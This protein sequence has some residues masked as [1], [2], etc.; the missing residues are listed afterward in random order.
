MIMCLIAHVSHCPC[1]PSPMCPIPQGTPSLFSVLTTI[2]LGPCVPLPMCP[3]AHVP[4]PP[5]CPISTCSI[6]EVMPMCPIS[7]VPHP[8]RCPIS[9]CSINHDILLIVC[10]IAHVFYCPYVKKDVTWTMKEV[11]KKNKLT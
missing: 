8:P 2:P 7:H 9:I 5:R 4:H 10:P 1:A 3:I 11:H 6:K